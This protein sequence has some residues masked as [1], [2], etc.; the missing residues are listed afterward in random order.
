MGTIHF[1]GL[2]ESNYIGGSDLTVA[3]IHLA[4]SETNASEL[5]DSA[6]FKGLVGLNDITKF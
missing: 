3:A 6:N 2:P 4:M 5:L 1:Q